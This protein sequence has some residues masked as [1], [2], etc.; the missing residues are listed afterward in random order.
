LIPNGV[1]LNRFRPGSGTRGRF[2]I[3]GDA[4]VILMVSA[5]ID[6]KRVL[7][8]IR[9]VSAIDGAHL[10]VAGDGP[11]RGQASEL[12]AEL[13][14]GRYLQLT[15]AASE[16]PA[17]YRSADV[18]LHLSLHESFGNVFLEAWASGLPIVAH[19]SSRI[20]WIVGDTQLLCDTRSPEQLTSALSAAL[21]KS[22]V[23]STAGIERF[24]W[25]NVALQ[26]R[27]AIDAA[28]ATR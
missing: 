20:R 15:L 7:D 8:G 14:P 11:L 24:A 12:A 25:S 13:L 17:L 22:S 26:Y 16:M 27:N 5:L 1:D 18:F 9:A 19:D 3:P 2:G 21:S 10:V 28:I 6:S 23:A 4:R